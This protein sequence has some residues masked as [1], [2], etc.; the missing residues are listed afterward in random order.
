MDCDH[1]GV[2]IK[3]VIKRTDRL[4]SFYRGV[5]WGRGG[6]YW[7][8]VSN[9][10][11]SESL[12]VHVDC[13]YFHSSQGHDFGILA[14]LLVCS[15]IHLPLFSLISCVSI[16]SHGKRFW[17]RSEWHFEGQLMEDPV[18]RLR[19]KSIMKKCGLRVW[20]LL[21]VAWWSDAIKMWQWISWSAASHIMYFLIKSLLS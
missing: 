16:I 13:N 3:C 14:D 8:H 5:K 9:E 17:L 10:L 1:W 21:P 12:C 6:D 2:F 19:F 11:D 18:N 15:C 20:K 4:I 7:W